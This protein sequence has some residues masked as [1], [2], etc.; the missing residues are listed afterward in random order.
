MGLWCSAAWGPAGSSVEIAWSAPASCPDE[1]WVEARVER[2]LDRP[3][4]DAAVEPVS[5]EVEV[6]VA[7]GELVADV[8][9][10]TG[11]RA[12]RRVL[13]DGSCDV[14]AAAAA[15]M[16]AVAIDPE[17]ALGDADEG[18]EATDPAAASEFESVEDPPSAVTEAPDTDEDPRDQT[19]RGQAVRGALGLRA[20]GAGGLLPGFSPAVGV[21]AAVLIGRARVEAHGDWTFE[22]T[23]EL[24]MGRS[25]SFRGWSAGAAACFVPASDPVEFP[26]CAGLSAGAM[27]GGSRGVADPGQATIPWVAGRVGPSL[28][29]VPSRF[30]AI[31]LGLDALVPL[32]RPQFTIENLGVVHEVWPVVVLGYL[33]VEVRFP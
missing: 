31:R 20:A 4:L 32:R 16:I 6:S 22:R 10:T 12:Q 13:R 15:F 1:A 25:A 28:A 17:A 2:F 30:A 29:Y 26:L 18:R 21:T 27:R 19:D 14:L 7:D 3:L 5:A 24:G 9:L 8:A 23:V 11:D 33:G